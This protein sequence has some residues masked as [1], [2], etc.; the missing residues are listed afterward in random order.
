MSKTQ[1]PAPK[2]K[3]D[4][5][6]SV[7]PTDAPHVSKTQKEMARAKLEELMK[8]ETRLV[9]G[10]FQCFETPGATV[11]VTVKKYKEVP[12]FEKEMTD[13]YQYEIPLY[14]ARHLNGYDM[15]A[16]AAA[17]PAEGKFGNSNIGTCSY[18]K[19]G[20]VMPSADAPLNPSMIGGI[21]GGA[22][23]I[24][25]PIVG[26]ERRVRRYGFQSLEFGSEM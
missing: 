16:G 15:T 24:P 11:K 1:A 13:G 25:V 26:I 19:H 14:V 23:G 21:P 7:L 10:R 6:S 8:Q 12:V 20:F 17:D 9:K 4:I 18:P 5:A 2:A 3:L 22:S